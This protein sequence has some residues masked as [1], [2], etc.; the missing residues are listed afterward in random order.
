MT[1]VDPKADMSILENVLMTPDSDAYIRLC[2]ET[3]PDL[4]KVSKY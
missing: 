4:Y 3:K 2:I 1:A